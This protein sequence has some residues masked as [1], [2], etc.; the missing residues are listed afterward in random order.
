MDG[1]ENNDEEGVV[2]YHGRLNIRPAF[3][4]EF[5]YK[6]KQKTEVIRTILKGFPLNTIYWSKA[7]DGYELL[8]GQQRIMSACT[9]IAG[10]FSV[11][12]S[13]L[14]DPEKPFYFHNLAQDVKD[15]VLDYEL[16]VYVCEGTDSEK[17]E[18]FR[19]INIAG[20]ELSE[21]EIRNAMYTGPWLADAK[22]KFSK[23]SSA[24][25][26]RARDYLP[27]SGIRQENLEL[28]LRWVSRRD[29]CTIEDYM[30]S[31]QRDANANDLWLYFCE[32]IDWADAT[33]PF[34]EK[35]KKGLD[36]GGFYERYHGTFSSDPAEL[37]ERFDRCMED[38]DVTKKSGI[39]EYLMSGDVRSLSIRA[40]EKNDIRTAYARCKGVC[41]RCGREG[42]SL[43][44]MEADHITPWSKGGHTKLDNLQMLCKDCNRR[45]SAV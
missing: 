7:G 21:Q 29:G 2:G 34:G 26:R 15:R 28:A 30:S 18:W 20:E 3:Q 37:R 8:D 40:F 13:V 27:G 10:D 14:P 25:F 42:L 32:V 38:S 9:Y 6:D 44:E 24:A 43:D 35:L 36:W 31:H 5:I 39:F 1:F 41:A 16:T 19:I 4:R 11:T 23:S 17:L 22:Y 12:S 33:F 45:K